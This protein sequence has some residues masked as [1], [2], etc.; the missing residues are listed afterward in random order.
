[1]E[2]GMDWKQKIDAWKER[3]KREAANREKSLRESETLVATKAYQEHIGAR[4][5]HLATFRCHI[6]GASSRKPAQKTEVAGA[7]CLGYGVTEE[8][9]EYV[10]DDWSKPGDLYQCEKCQK[11]T[12]KEHIYN[13]ICQKCAEKL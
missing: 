7:G 3:V 9:K 1:M 4:Y 8:S 12:C 13:G 2:V 6:C 5:R 11:W 10:V